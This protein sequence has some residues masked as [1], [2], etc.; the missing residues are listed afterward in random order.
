MFFFI[1][2][3]FTSPIG[4][5]SNLKIKNYI[6]LLLNR[7]FYI[8]NSIHRFL[9]GLL[10]SLIPIDTLAFVPQRQSSIVTCLRRFAT[11]QVFKYCY[12]SLVV[13]VTPLDSSI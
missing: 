2:E 7:L 6:N 10:G 5:V 12:T 13:F 4:Y 9:L 8:H 11:P 1:R 3:I